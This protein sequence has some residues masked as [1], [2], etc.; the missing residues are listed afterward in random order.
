M[1]DEIIKMARGAGLH[2]ATD[3]NWMPIIGIEYAEKLAALV[4]AAKEQEMR[5]SGWRQC[6][7][8][9]RTT[10]FCGQLEAERE[11]L[12]SLYDQIRF[13]LYDYKD[14][15]EVYPNSQ[16]TAVQSIDYLMVGY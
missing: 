6:A 15:P 8:G 13:A 16:Q 5:E 3:V 10:Q 9:Q 1:K 14:K 11:K 2:I 7:K 4:A 12:K